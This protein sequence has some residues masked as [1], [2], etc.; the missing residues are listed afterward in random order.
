MLT[1]TSELKSFVL[2]K[3]NY[4]GQTYGH[5]DDRSR[6]YLLQQTHLSLAATFGELYTSCHNIL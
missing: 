2:P 1:Q 5:F 6:T 3:I 4:V